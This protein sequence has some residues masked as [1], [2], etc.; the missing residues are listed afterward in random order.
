MDKDQKSYVKGAATGIAFGA[1]A[2]AIAGIL[3]APKSGK[4]TRKDITKWTES[5]KDEIAKKLH[6]AG[7]FTK[8]KYEQISNTVVDTYTEAKKI[9][10][11]E[12]KEFKAGLS[13]NYEKVKK[14]AQ[15]KS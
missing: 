5:M 8:E 2:G 1:L 9:S 4:E 14:A 11:K 10:A 7:D 12:A 13:E 15:K 3:L 6:A